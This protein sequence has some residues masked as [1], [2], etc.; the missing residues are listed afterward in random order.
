MKKKYGMVSPE[1]LVSLAVVLFS[2]L[3]YLFPLTPIRPPD[4]PYIVGFRTFEITNPEPMVIES[5]GYKDGDR[6]RLDIW[7]PAQ[8][9]E[10]C[11][12]KSWID[13]DPRLFEGFEKITGYPVI[14]FQHL[15]QVKA[16]SYIDAQ[17]AETGRRYPVVIILPGWSSIS[18]LHTSFAELLA[19]NGYLVVSIEHPGACT[20]V[21]F[22]NG[23]TYYFLGN[24]AINDFERIGMSMEEIID[25]LAAYLAKDI[26]YVLSFLKDMNTNSD[27]EFLHKIDLEK[28]ALYGH[29]GGGAVAVEYALQHNVGAVA[30]AD[31]TMTPFSFK[32]LENGISMPAL[33]IES[34]EWEGGPKHEKMVKLYENTHSPAYYLRVRGTKHVDFAMVRRLSP[35]TYF[36]G[37]TGKFMNTKNG[38]HYIDLSIKIFFDSVFFDTPITLLKE[39]DN[40]IPEFELE[41][42]VIQ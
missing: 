39:L 28:I 42:S 35:L 31:P 38:L 12:R 15:Y 9:I 21:S 24:D 8:N 22:S 26:D 36:F 27:S 3:I 34:D 17:P 33:F 23:S 29:S 20:V 11:E 14:L 30:L 41:S 6:I 16:N 4:G 40:R 7:Y 25:M 18:E 13:N 10:A 5:T 19:S 37:E 2:V 1:I 32:E